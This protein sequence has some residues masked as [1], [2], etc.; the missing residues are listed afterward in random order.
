M[1]TY[2]HYYLISSRVQNFL[3]WI[4][5]LTVLFC[6]GYGLW[7]WGGWW[8][9]AALMVVGFAFSWALVSMSP[10]ECDDD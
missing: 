4:I 1:N 2:R 6:G 8:L 7:V 5:S 9:I 10:P 3:N